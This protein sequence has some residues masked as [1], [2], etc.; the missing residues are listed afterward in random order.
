[1]RVRNFVLAA[2][3]VIAAGI[4]SAADWP[5]WRGPDRSGVSGETGLLKSIPEGGPKLLWTFEE[6]GIGYSGP[7]VVGTRLYS[8]GAD[9]DADKEFVFCIDTSTGKEV[10]RTPFPKLSD[11]TKLLTQWGGGPRGTPTID[12]DVLYVLGVKGDLVCAE[13]ETGKIRWQKNMVKDYGGRVMQQWGWCESPLVDGEKLICCP[14][15]ENGTVAALDKKTGEVL[16]RSRDFTDDASYASPVVATIAGVKQ[17]VVKSDKHLAGVSAADGK[18]L[19]KE[20][21]GVNS[22][23]V[24]PTP[25]VSGDS[26]FTTCG[27]RDRG[28]SCGLVTIAP[29]DGGFKPSVAWK[30]ANL[31]NHHGGVLLI[32]DHLYGYSDGDR[33][34][35]KKAGWVCIELKSGNEVWQSDKHEKGSLTAADGKLFCWGEKKDEIVVVEASPAG[36]SEL[37]RFTPHKKSPNRKERGGF[38]THPV[39][40]HGK[41]YLRDQEL[42]FCYDVTGARAAD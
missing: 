32:G 7:A 9:A 4:V 39:I 5:Q 23:A 16:W 3:L 29:A 12:G 19:W 13:L 18:L 2:G 33:R 6:A 10:W 41:L 14:G 22:I 34:A 21:I 20:P 25:I 40:A 36:W 38:W 28:G 37:G 35:N 26:V 24:I 11:D 15:Y 8:A 17:Y 30:D 27:Y 1:M 31:F 42:L